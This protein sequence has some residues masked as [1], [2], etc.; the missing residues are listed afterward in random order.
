MNKLKR[1][2]IVLLLAVPLAVAGLYLFKTLDARDGLTSSQ[3]NCVLKDS[4]GYLWF[5]TTAGL[6][7]YDGYTFR[8]FQCNSQDGSSLPDSYI[9]SMQETLEG[10][11][12]IET[13]AGFCV[14]HPQT[15]NFERDMKQV[16]ARMGIE[17]QPNVVYVD[18]HKNF[19]ASIPNKGVVAYNQQQQTSYEFGY[20]NDAVGIPQG[21]ICSISECRDGAVLVYD[22]GR[23]VCCDIMHQ[24]HTVWQTDF[25]AEHGLRRSKSLKAFADQMDNIWLY[26]QG[27]LMMYNKNTNQWDTNI[28]NQLGLTGISVDHIVNGMAGDKRGNIWI[29]SDQLG[30]M[31]MDE[32]WYSLLRQQYL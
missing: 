15:E 2:L 6:Y 28:G 22:D 14:Y 21:V 10:T 11:L 27:T 3:V 20:T 16:Y 12:W 8:N 5:G 17:G 9:I 25:I 13:S 32:V 7:R 26:G 4:R 24:Q 23:L 19:W 31:K 29:G 18:R 30:L 1:I